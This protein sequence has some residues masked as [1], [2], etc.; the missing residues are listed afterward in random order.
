MRAAQHVR[1][2]AA[3]EL[4]DINDDMCELLE[5]AKR[6]MRRVGGFDN[7]RARAY[8]LGA[9]S[10]ELDANHE[11]LG[12]SMCAM[13]DTISELRG[14]GDEPD[15]PCDDDDDNDTTSHDDVLDEAPCGTCKRAQGACVCDDDATSCDVAHDDN[16]DNVRS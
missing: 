7:D 16:D 11:Y 6:V 1:S 9:L 10:I 12:G 4:Q 13:Y 14:D 5:R 2:E 8:W 15:E 3:R